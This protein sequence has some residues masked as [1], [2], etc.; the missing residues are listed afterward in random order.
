[1]KV[2]ALAT[3]NWV[4]EHTYLLIHECFP[5]ST[6]PTLTFCMTMCCAKSLQLGLTLCDPVDC[7]PPSSFVPGISQARI[8]EWIAIPFSTG[9]SGPRDRTF[10]SCIA[11]RLFTIWAAR[12]ALIQLQY[13]I[14]TR[15]LTL[16]QSTELIWIL[17][18]KDIHLGICVSL[19]AILSS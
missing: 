14:K 2:R 8:L 3:H 16:V 9:T 15:W 13:N 10:I 4:M 17:S 12:R 1:M 5:T 6:S 18:A 7:R 11:G 19:Y